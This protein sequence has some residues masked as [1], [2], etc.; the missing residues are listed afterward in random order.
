[1]HEFPPPSPRQPR[2][3]PPRVSAHHRSPPHPRPGQL[4]GAAYLY[5]DGARRRPERVDI[6]KLRVTVVAQPDPHGHRDWGEGE[7]FLTEVELS[8]G[9]GLRGGGGL[10]NARVDVAVNAVR[11]TAVGAHPAP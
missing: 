3:G 8:R 9:E 4:A 1:M 2:L 7:G 5:P 10:L 11:V 6:H